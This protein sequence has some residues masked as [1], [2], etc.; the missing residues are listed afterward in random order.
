MQPAQWLS[1]P[2]LS[3]ME[4]GPSTACATWAGVSPATSL[5]GA[6]ALGALLLV[7]PHPRALLQSVHFVGETDRAERENALPT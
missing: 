3:P 2:Y 7:T 6:K 1:T 5:L 4:G